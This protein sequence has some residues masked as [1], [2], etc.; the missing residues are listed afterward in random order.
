NRTG[1]PKGRLNDATIQGRRFCQEIMQSAEYRESIRRRIA[2]DTLPAVLEVE[3]LHY[4]WGKPPD[5]VRITAAMAPSAE[6]GLY[7]LTDAELAE[8]AELLATICRAKAD[9]NAAAEKVADAKQ[10]PFI[11]L[12][13]HLHYREA[14]ADASSDG[15]EQSVLPTKETSTK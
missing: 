11:N 8:R 5:Y 14:S 13:P 7:G 6:Q 10:K 15:K 12:L 2:N 1:R 4:A 9:A 3:L